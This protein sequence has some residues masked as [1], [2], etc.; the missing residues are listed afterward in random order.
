VIEDQVKVIAEQTKAK[1]DQSR[2]GC[3]LLQ[4]LFNPGRFRMIEVLPLRSGSS[5]SENSV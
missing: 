5:P 1:A 2:I 4:I 3:D